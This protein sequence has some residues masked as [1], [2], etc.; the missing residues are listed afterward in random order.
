VGFESLFLGGVLGGVVGIRRGVQKV[1]KEKDS[2]QKVR[3]WRGTVGLGISPISHE[4]WLGQFGR[5]RIDRYS[6]KG[7]ERGKRA[8]TFS[9]SERYR[10]TDQSWRLNLAEENV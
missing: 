4:G 2:S 7:K 10:F 6:S 3:V 5:N 8:S 1:S 9:S